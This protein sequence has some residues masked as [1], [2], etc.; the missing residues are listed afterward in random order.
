MMVPITTKRLDT[1]KRVMKKKK[2]EKERCTSR[3]IHQKAHPTIAAR[4]KSEKITSSEKIV[5]TTG[6]WLKE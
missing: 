2:M 1:G 3:F 4:R 6:I 5:V